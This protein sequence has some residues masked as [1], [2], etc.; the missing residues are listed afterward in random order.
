MSQSAS[1]KPRPV[2]RSE[3]EWRRLVSEYE[4]SGTTMTRFSAER[5]L[6]RSSLSEWRKRFR[7][8]SPTDADGRSGGQSGPL[9]ELSGLFD[10]PDAPDP[11]GHWRVELDLGGGT[12]LR[13]R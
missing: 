11:A 1:E 4:A 3:E 9:I 7:D 13:L 8:E 6:A 5:G 10:H 12:V 2:I